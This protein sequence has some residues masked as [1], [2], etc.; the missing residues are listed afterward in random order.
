MTTRR[1]AV[2]ALMAVALVG[3]KREQRRF[4][5]SPPAATASNA[6]LVSELQPGPAFVEAGM[7]NPYEDNAYAVSEGKNLFNQMNCS[8]CHSHGGGGIGPPL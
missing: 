2:A 7:R 5:E 6:L 8:G 4:R 3:C 1:F